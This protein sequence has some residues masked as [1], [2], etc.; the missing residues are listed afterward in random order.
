MRRG[1][2]LIEIMVSVVIVSLVAIAV[3]A[4]LASGIRLWRRGNL[5]RSFSRQVRVSTE[6]LSREIRNIFKFS[7]IDFAGKED[8]LEFAGLILN[9]TPDE[10]GQVQEY[11]EVG[12]VSYLFDQAE[13]ALYKKET[14]YYLLQRE[15]EEKEQLPGEVV[16]SELEE[17]KFSY[18]YLDSASAD[19]KWKSNWDRQEQH[20]LPLAVKF[21]MTFEDPEQPALEN[22]VLIPVGTGEQSVQ[23]S[24]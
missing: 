1:F 2:T 22:I 18:C 24:E 4:V 6:K 12:K 14:P 17:V 13:Q 10:D 19:H 23:S 8:S 11:Y 20:S 3:Y 15:E 9:K 5:D 16:I 7:K 21:E